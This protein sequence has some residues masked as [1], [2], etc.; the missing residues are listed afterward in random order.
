MA[1]H[2]DGESRLRRYAQVF[3]REANPPANL[4]GSLMNGLAM[5]RPAPRRGLVPAFAM[6]AGVLVA[7]LVIAFGALQLHNLGRPSPV[8]TPPVSITSPTPSATP[9]TSATPSATPTATPTPAGAE[10]GFIPPLA[11]IQMVG[12]HLGWAVGSHAIYATTDG[13]HWTKQFGSTDD[14]VG[15][16]FISGTTGWVVGTHRLL[17]TSDGGRS[18]HELGEA[19]QLIRSVHFIS[20]TRGWGIA[21]GNQPLVEHGVLIPGAG[22]TLIMSTDGGRSWVDLKSPGDPQTMCFSDAAHGWLASA[23]GIIYKS[24]DG[25]QTWTQALKM[26]S[27]QPGSSGWARIECAGPSALWVLWAP[28]GAAAGH[29]P[30]V[31]YATVNGQTWR[32]V[33]AEP[34]TIG[35]SL[36]G[37]PAGPGSYPGSI[38]VVDASDAVVVGDTP[39]AN[40][41]TTMIVSNGGATLK[42]TGAIAGAVQTFD[43]AFV[44]TTTGWVLAHNTSGADVIAA[45]TDGGYHW[46]QQLSIGP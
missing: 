12:P 24:Q 32:T 4:A 8:V 42:T 25:G 6:A 21:G 5:P 17:A 2:V 23:A 28:G 34:G 35:N 11:A 1:N 13:T 41:A 7:A 43:A 10:P 15:L 45:T 20:A 46:S 31:V 37:V 39:P 19:R 27:S 38:S 16:D 36:P 14:F 29:Q 30:Y 9:E 22:A 3:R 33:M 26:A 40:A 44:T 18:W